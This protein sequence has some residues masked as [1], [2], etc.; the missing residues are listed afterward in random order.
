MSSLPKVGRKTLPLLSTLVLFLSIAAGVLLIQER[1]EI[2]ERA[3]TAKS[4]KSTLVQVIDTSQFSP[5]SPDPAGIAYLLS[6]NRL[7]VSDS[8]VNEMSIFTGVNLFN[9]TLGGVLEKTSTTVA[10]SNEP[11]G[12][13]YNPTNG[14]IFISD[15]NAKEIFEVDHGSDGVYGSS[16]DIITSFDTKAFNSND[17]E[18]V[19]YNSWDGSLYIADGVNTEIYRVSSGVNGLFDGISPAGD[20]QVTSFD[21][22][23]L[24]VNDPEGIAFNLDNGN[25]YIVGKP[26]TNV[27][28]VTTKGKLVQNIDISAANAKKPAGLAYAPG[29]NDVRQMHL[30]IV[31]RGVDN[32]ANP[33][34]N[35]GKIYEMTLPLSGNSTPTPT[36]SPTVTP[37]PTTTPTSFIP[38]D[39][40]KD[41]DVDIFDYNTLVSNFGNTNC[42][43]KADI[44]T[45][46]DVDIFDYNLLVGNFGK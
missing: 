43:N 9:V 19:S 29:S 35:D 5:P 18:G 3:Q 12:V 32:N 26:A 28:E 20:D 31:E 6:K 40:D 46:C 1:Q 38:G 25:L 27:A 10:F 45:D 24:G 39:I 42:G 16:D 44:D 11:T 30:Y 17:P 23:S 13:S 14:H 8:E 36:K 7:L 33:N 21:T 4:F 2:R 41:N 15:D 37:K 22:A 34:E